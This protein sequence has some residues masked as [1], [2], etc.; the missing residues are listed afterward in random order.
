MINCLNTNK[1]LIEMTA[2]TQDNQAADAKKNDTEF[3]FKKQA[4]MYTRQLEQERQAKAALEQEL[5]ALKQQKSQKRDMEEED[6]G[7][8]PYIDKKVLKKTLTNERQQVKEEVRNEVRQ[9]MQKMIQDERKNTFLRQNPD[10]NE[11]MTPEMLQKFADKHPDI[12]DE[13]MN[14]PDGFD[15]QRFLYKNVKA[16]GINRK[17]EKIQDKIDDKKR[18]NFYQPSGIAGPGYS[19][20][21][22]FSKQGQKAAYDKILALKNNL[23][24]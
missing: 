8:E 1:R 4:D 6:D 20:Q 9:E 19:A 2:N 14:M 17:E 15:R 23:R 13:Y 3:N 7:D 5:Q 16:L 22:D 24:I 21:G 12:A 10:F 18:A 11:I